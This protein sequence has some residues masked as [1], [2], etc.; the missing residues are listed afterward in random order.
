MKTSHDKLIRTVTGLIC[1]ALL[2]AA[3][4]RLNTA[5]A[6]DQSVVD[7]V[8][9]SVVEIGPIIQVTDVHN[10]KSLLAF[11]WA[12][13]TV[14]R[15]DGFILTSHHAVDS[16]SLATQLKGKQGVKVMQGL[17]AVYTADP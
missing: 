1:T 2:L 3:A 4:A 16:A 12:S 13:G 9:Q 11:E 15:S 5:S 17:F 14:I 10:K 7:S 6:L 8:T